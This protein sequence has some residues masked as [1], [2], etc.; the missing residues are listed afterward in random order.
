MF[1]SVLEVQRWCGAVCGEMMKRPRD[2]FEV[3]LTKGRATCKSTMAGRHGHDT[4]GRADTRHD[5]YVGDGQELLALGAQSGAES[6]LLVPRLSFDSSI[7]AWPEEGTVRMPRPWR[8]FPSTS[9]SISLGGP[10]CRLLWGATCSVVS[11]TFSGLA[12]PLRD[13]LFAQV[14]QV[15]VQKAKSGCTS[16]T[17]TGDPSEAVRERGGLTLPRLPPFPLSAQTRGDPTPA[18]HSSSRSPPPKLSFLHSA[19]QTV[20]IPVTGGDFHLHFS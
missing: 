6:P 2:A 3:S 5:R 18:L 17:V 12:R 9:R 20:I 16:W 4:M 13:T 14:T 1:C 8:A 11:R 19:T 15:S 7:L 10:G